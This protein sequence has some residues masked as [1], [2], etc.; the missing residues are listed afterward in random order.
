[1]QT[2]NATQVRKDWSSV[3]DS[4]T[5]EKKP[6]MIKRTRD[7]LLLTE[8][9]LFSELL[10]AYN[11]HAK[12][13]TE[14]DGSVTISLD[15][16][17][18]VENGKNKAEAL[19]KLASAILEYAEDYYEDFSYWSRGDRRAHIPYVIKALVIGDTNKIGGLIKCRRGGT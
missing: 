1:M 2:L 17:D 7:Y 4:V 13:F 6:V 15:E 19:Q 18:L 8:A 11:F 12:I 9:N 10:S 3:L 5:R 16:L 14:E